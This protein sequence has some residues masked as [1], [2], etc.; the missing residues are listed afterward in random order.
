MDSIN[1]KTVVGEEK[2]E[3]L[4]GSSPPIAD[5]VWLGLGG[6][7]AR[8]GDFIISEEMVEE[9]SKI[10]NH[11]CDEIPPTEQEFARWVLL[12]QRMIAGDLTSHCLPIGKFRSLDGFKNSV[13]TV[14]RMVWR[15]L[16]VGGVYTPEKAKAYDP[17][18]G[19][20]NE[21][22]RADLMDKCISGY[23]RRDA[24]DR[25]VNMA[26]IVYIQLLSSYR[27]SRMLKIMGLGMR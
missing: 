21:A 1:K 11:L 12:H 9:R 5:L 10:R 22:V 8:A 3:G 15:D 2:E 16:A 13:S 17:F 27:G 20:V 23:R 19:V 14:L 7:I 6:D 18:E 26:R 25:V 24:T 4:G